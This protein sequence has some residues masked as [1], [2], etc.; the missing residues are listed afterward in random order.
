MHIIGGDR[1]EWV[2]E[3]EGDGR[4]MDHS[5][6]CRLGKGRVGST[7]EGLAGGYI[8]VRRERVNGIIRQYRVL[9]TTQGYWKSRKRP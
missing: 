4:D 5:A 3:E 8:P 1:G 2:G 6:I 7:E 9:R